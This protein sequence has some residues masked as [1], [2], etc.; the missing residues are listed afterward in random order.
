M[1]EPKTTAATRRKLNIFQKIWQFFVGLSLWNRLA[2]IFL[3]IAPIAAFGGLKLLKPV[4][5]SW[6]AKNSLK[7]AAKAVEED[8]MKTASLA[9]RSAIRSRPDDPDVWRQVGAFLDESGSPESRG[10][11]ERVVKLDPEDADAKLSLIKSSIKAGQLESARGTFAELP[12][13]EKGT[14]RYHRA[15]AALAMAQNDS[16]AAEAELLKLLELEPESAEAKWDLTR[17]RSLS[18]NLEVRRD[19]RDELRA[20]GSGSGEYSLP[21]LRHLVRLS[22]GEKDFYT[23]NRT[24]EDLIAHPD[25]TGQER[26]LFLD[27]EFAVQSFTLPNS[28]SEILE[29]AEENPGS[30]PEI[31]A[32]LSARGLND[33]LKTWFDGLDE[34]VKG[35][36]AVQLALFNFSLKIGDWDA[37]F[38]VLRNENS[39]HPFSDVLIGEVESALDAYRRGDS[40]AIAKWK[41]GVFTA[42]NNPGATGVM[43]SL[44]EAVD[45]R[46]AYS[47][48]LWSLASSVSTRPEIWMSVVRMELAEKNSAGILSALA[49]AI[50]ADPENRQ[51]RNDW[52]LMN[53]L[54][55]QGD[56]GD[57][58]GLAEENAEY[59]PENPFYATTLGLA[60]ALD[61]RDERAVESISALPVAVK[62]DPEKALYV[63]TVLAM[64]GRMEEAKP[65]LDSSQKVSDKLLPEER[66]L[67]DRA[68][69]L[70]SGEVSLDSKANQI[71]KRHVMSAAEREEFSVTLKAQRDRRDAG[72]SSEE[73]TESLRQATGDRRSP[74]EIQNIL[75]ELRG[76][77]ADTEA[78]AN[79]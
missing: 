3:L 70:V 19:A 67:R 5:H 71:G 25:S 7:I 21:A 45:W 10:V 4:Y 12:D 8:D 38:E 11:W 17:I 33:R 2:L 23:A 75:D 79:P 72:V 51:L 76:N 42:E 65:Y 1:S 50:R 30:A 56:L 39:P 27:S 59:D 52:V 47:L 73:I 31:T 68:Q 28:I 34:D 9:F 32:Y 14:A 13:S 43:A 46:Q 64:A 15:A 36:M 26:I 6:K 29:F 78:P 60:L 62:N 54:L 53:L 22:L 61:G 57:L 37:L 24:A 48:S 35:E 63:G 41:K 44:A 69:A 77:P 40:E 66:A 74:E 55:Q 58:I 49:G 16:D 20:L 18:P